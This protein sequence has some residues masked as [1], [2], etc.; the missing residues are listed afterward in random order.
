MTMQR[1]ATFAPVGARTVLGQLVERDGTLHFEAENGQVY[2]EDALRDGGVLL[3][4]PSDGSSPSEL[5]ALRSLCRK[6]RIAVG[7]RRVRVQ[8]PLDAA[9]DPAV[10]SLPNSDHEPGPPLHV[11]GRIHGRR[12]SER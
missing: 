7:I 10:K 4:G 5:I 3:P 2:Q 1:S 12:L 6:R 8:V 9:V 11:R